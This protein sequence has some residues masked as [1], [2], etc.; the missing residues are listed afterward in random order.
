MAAV[1]SGGDR[2]DL[3]VRIRQH[4][5]AAAAEVKQKGAANDLMQRLAG[6]AAF[7]TV[8]LDEM[9]DPARFVGRAS[10]QVDEFLA[11]VVAPIRKRYPEKRAS[12]VE[13]KV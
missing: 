3:H 6:D 8:N 12:E 11:E 1:A 10:E 4:S 13:I 5:Q 9:L 2:Q 7:K